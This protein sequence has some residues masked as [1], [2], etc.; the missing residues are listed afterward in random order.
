MDLDDELS[1]LTS[2]MERL[3]VDINQ[4]R[5]IGQIEEEYNKALQEKQILLEQLKIAI[6]E[7]ERIREQ[8]KGWTKVNFGTTKDTLS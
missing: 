5:S 7:L 3:K 6:A 2:K 1:Q 8:L 4:P